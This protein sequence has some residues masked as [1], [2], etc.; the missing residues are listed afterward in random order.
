MYMTIIVDVDHL[1]QWEYSGFREPLQLVSM[2]TSVWAGKLEFWVR[3]L[4]GTKIFLF[5]TSRFALRITLPPVY[6]EVLIFSQ[7]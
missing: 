6:Y 3:Y 1:M 7:I 5:A 4:G 2:V